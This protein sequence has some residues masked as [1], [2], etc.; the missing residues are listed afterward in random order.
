MKVRKKRELFSASEARH[1][2][3]SKGENAMTVMI[4][5]LF[6]FA[7]GTVLATSGFAQS[8]REVRS[9]APF[10]PIANTSI[11]QH[12]KYTLY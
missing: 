5:T 4:R 11:K 6:A 9:P 7:V 3:R 1:N 12:R 8:A 2:E 10:I